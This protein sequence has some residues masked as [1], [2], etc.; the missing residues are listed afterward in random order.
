M[1]AFQLSLPS[2]PLGIEHSLQL[3]ML[4]HRGLYITKKQREAIMIL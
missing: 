3:W 2:S 1:A 4:R